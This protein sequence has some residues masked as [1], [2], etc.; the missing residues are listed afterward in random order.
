MQFSVDS[1]VLSIRLLPARQALT[2]PIE[3]APGRGKEAEIE[4]LG[5]ADAGYHEADCNFS[6]VGQNPYSLFPIP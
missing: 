3:G 1:F 2:R 4:A 5:N 6:K